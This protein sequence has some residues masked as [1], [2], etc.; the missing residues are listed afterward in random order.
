[1]GRV[2]RGEG[3]LQDHLTGV[4]HD[5]DLLPRADLVPH[6]D[7]E[8]VDGA[9]HRRTDVAVV[10]DGVVVALG[11]VQADLG[12]LHVGGSVAVL[13]LV[14]L[15][16]GSD[17]IPFLKIGGKD[18]AL[19]QRLDG[20]AV[21][22]VQGAGGAQGLGDGPPGDRG[23]GIFGGHLHR[24]GLARLTDGDGRGDHHHDNKRDSPLE[25]FF[26][27]G[28]A[29]G[30]CCAGGCLRFLAGGLAFLFLPGHGNLSS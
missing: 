24:L 21:G 2:G 5:S 17:F 23:L 11:L 28:Q 14:Q 18:L 12:L 13:D 1:M 25:M 30:G 6:L 16:A 7:A 20:V 10:G 27:L 15:L 22:R 8:G 29:L 4:L 9:R 26:I 3:Q 19:H